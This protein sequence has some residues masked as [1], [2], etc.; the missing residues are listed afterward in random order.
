VWPSAISVL[1]QP[2]HILLKCWTREGRLHASA[3]I[4]TGKI[5]NPD[6]RNDPP[7]TLRRPQE[8]T[9]ALLGEKGKKGEG[10]LKREAKWE[11]LR[12]LLSRQGYSLWAP[13]GRNSEFVWQGE[14]ERS[15]GG[16]RDFSL[17]SRLLAVAKESPEEGGR[18]VIK[19]AG[20][21]EELTSRR[22]T[23]F[24]TRRRGKTGAMGRKRLSGL[25]SQGGR[26]AYSLCSL[27]PVGKEQFS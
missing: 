18:G 1:L 19:R 7:S 23:T 22:V 13:N 5:N 12:S 10:I 9:K 26:K 20:R 24:P 15:R 17:Y 27:N 11:M 21:R 4:K 8:E 3:D 6:G 14:G 2:I 25:S 16:G